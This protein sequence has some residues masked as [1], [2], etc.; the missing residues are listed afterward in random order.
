MQKIIWFFFLTWSLSA[1]SQTEEQREMDSLRLVF[2]E[3]Y[4]ELFSLHPI[5]HVGWVTDYEQLYSKSEK[6]MLNSLIDQYEKETTVE[7]VIVTIDST[8]VSADRFEELSLTIANHWGVGKFG[9]DNGVLIAISKDYRKIRI[10]NGN[11]IEK[12]LT[13]E[14]TYEIIHKVFIPAFRN[15][16]YFEGTI[17]GVKELIKFLNKKGAKDTFSYSSV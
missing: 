1:F 10:Q 13:N 14:E 4:R 3:N 8:R 11:G 15:G 6:A 12:I 16:N 17:Q 2:I 7:I 9:K 5:H